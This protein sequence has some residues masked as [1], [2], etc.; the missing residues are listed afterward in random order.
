[1]WGHQG[2]HL[3][4]RMEVRALGPH[5]M[6]SSSTS[7]RSRLVQLQVQSKQHLTLRNNHSGEHLDKVVVYLQPAIPSRLT[8]LSC[9]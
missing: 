4:Q 3:G 7:I 9:R 8:L 6:Y 5:S 1:V 2:R